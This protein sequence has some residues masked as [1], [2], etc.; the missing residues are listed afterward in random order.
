MQPVLGFVARSEPS[1]SDPEG[2]TESILRTALAG[3]RFLLTWSCRSPG[4]AK[5]KG[6]VPCW[7]EGDAGPSS[8]P[9]VEMVL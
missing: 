8:N 7:A 4:K 1:C 5:A 9:A 6:R 2:C 3:S